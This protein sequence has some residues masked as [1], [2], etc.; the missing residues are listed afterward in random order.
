MRVK[1]ETFVYLEWLMLPTNIQPPPPPQTPSTFLTP[2]NTPPSMEQ[3]N[4]YDKEIKTPSLLPPRFLYNGKENMDGYPVIITTNN[5]SRSR[6]HSSPPS[7]IPQ[8]LSPPS[9]IIP[10]DEPIFF[11]HHQQPSAMFPQ[12]PQHHHQSI[13]GRTYSTPITMHDYETLQQQQQNA[14]HNPQTLLMPANQSQ[15]T[16]RFSGIFRSIT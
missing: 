9:I 12:Q 8:H 10:D 7:T 2:P 15:T 6:T 4:L 11:P 14:T 16:V 13:R 1:S 3:L 5:T